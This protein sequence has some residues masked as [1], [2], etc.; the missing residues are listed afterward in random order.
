[1]KWTKE[2]FN[3]M[4][5]PKQVIEQIFVPLTEEERSRL[6]P[7][8]EKAECKPSQE[9]LPRNPQPSRQRNLRPTPDEM[10]LSVAQEDA[11]FSIPSPPISP[12][13]KRIGK[14]VDVL[15]EVTTR[16]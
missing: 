4:P 16:Q 5:L 10:F 2:T 8:W 11:S 12:Q 15:S 1:M 13:S 7:L 9:L 6:P 14:Q 3:L